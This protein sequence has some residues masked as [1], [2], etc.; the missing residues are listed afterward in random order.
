MILKEYSY[1]DIKCLKKIFSTISVEDAKNGA[2]ILGVNLY[3]FFKYNKYDE[4]FPQIEIFINSL[5]KNYFINIDKEKIY[6]YTSKIVNYFYNSNSKTLDVNNFE[7]IINKY[8]DKKYS[9]GLPKIYNE[10]IYY[11]TILFNKSYNGLI[12]DNLIKSK[13][14][15][16][17]RE[18]IDKYI[19]VKKDISEI[20]VG[21]DERMNQ[22]IEDI[23]RLR[24]IEDI[25]NL[26]PSYYMFF[27]HEDI[28]YYLFSRNELLSFNHS[29]QLEVNKTINIR[30]YFNYSNN[31]LLEIKGEKFLATTFLKLIFLYTF[32]VLYKEFYYNELIQNNEFN[33]YLNSQKIDLEK[34]MVFLE[35]NIEIE[36]DDFKGIMLEIFPDFFV[37]NYFDEYEYLKNNNDININIYFGDN[38]IHYK[39]KYNN[40]NFFIKPSDEIININ[41]FDFESSIFDI[42]YDNHQEKTNIYGLIKK[43]V[44]F[45]I[46][47]TIEDR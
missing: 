38:Y 42:Q 40:Y 2:V 39:K 47:N 13:F 19:E 27:D 23:K 3:N 31:K 12:E 16:S 43:I 35:D 21:V 22:N 30:F 36:F 37:S 11:Y 41:S 34:D 29:G 25:K 24:D 26:L 15:L 1:E 28:F 14:I 45:I 7:Y 32:Y 8:Y 9:N 44:M 20:Y 46:S 17:E 5:K 18:Y 6:I 33:F 4:S 10:N